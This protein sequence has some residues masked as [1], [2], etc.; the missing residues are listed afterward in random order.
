PALGSLPGPSLNVLHAGMFEDAS[1]R[2][3]RRPAQV[4][5]ILRRIH[6]CTDLIHHAAEVNVRANFGSQFLAGHD[7]QLMIELA[8]N[9]LNLPRVVVKMR[10]LA[11]N[12]QVPAAGE[13]AS[14]TLFP[15][16]LLDTI[17]RSQ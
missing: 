11:S 12:F 7:F 13:I 3:H 10:L 14:N 6:S 5:H 15:Y 9:D 8:R 16:N 1:S 17:D 2:A 4:R